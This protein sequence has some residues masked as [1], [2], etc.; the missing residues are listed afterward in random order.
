MVFKATRHKGNSFTYRRNVMHSVTKQIIMCFV[1]AQNNHSPLC[2]G[3]RGTITQIDNIIKQIKLLHN[4]SPFRN[5]SDVVLTAHKFQH[6]SVCSVSVVLSVNVAIQFGLL[7]YGIKCANKHDLNVN[8][9]SHVDLLLMTF[10]CK[11]HKDGILSDTYFTMIIRFKFGP[12]IVSTCFYL[13]LV[14][15]PLN[16]CIKIL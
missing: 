12:L 10:V 4:Y 3:R 14:T 1:T 11:C 7:V 2:L 5:W 16:H 8:L 6:F 15:E 13:R 9:I